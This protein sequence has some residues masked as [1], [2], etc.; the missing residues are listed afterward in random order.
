MSDKLFNNNDVSYNKR[1]FW[2]Y[3]RLFGGPYKNLQTRNNKIL[4]N[5]SN[6][7]SNKTLNNTSNN[8]STK[9]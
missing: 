8:K 6:N 2:E 1:Q 5:T 7:K 3:K 9:I 4:N